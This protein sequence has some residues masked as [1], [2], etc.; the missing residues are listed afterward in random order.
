MSK[1]STIY[2]NL[3]SQD[4][5]DKIS[6]ENKLL[7]NE[8]I[9]YCKSEDK[10]EETIRV[11]KSDLNIFFC[12]NFEHNLNKNFV[13]IKIKDI[14]KYQNFLINKNQSPARIRS[15][16]SALSSLSNY[17]ETICFE[18]YPDF[19]NI[20]NKIKP[21]ANTAVREKTILTEDEVNKMLIL[22]ANGKY[23]QQ[24]CYLALAAYSGSRKSE[25]LKFKVNYF[26]KENYNPKTGLFKMPETIRTKGKGKLGKQLKKYTFWKYFEPYFNLW[27]DERKKLGITSEWLFV[28]KNNNQAKI[29]TAN[30]WSQ[31]IT[32]LTGK[33]IYWH[34]FRH[35][36]DTLLNK[37]N[38]PSSVIMEIFGWTSSEMVQYYNDQQVEDDFDKY[39]SEDGIKFVEK[40]NSL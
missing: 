13:D 6:N 7:F 16:K 19:R 22:L 3:T 12:W 4:K 35:F 32:N 33:V 2:N 11:Y 21:P 30:Y 27:M 23:Y 36:L 8:F 40:N 25:L 28:T 29:S 9:E 17:I 39:F 20:I 38:I 31:Q 1:R 18:E 15:L 24:A 14:I 5:L 10:S 26:Q 37:N 34:C